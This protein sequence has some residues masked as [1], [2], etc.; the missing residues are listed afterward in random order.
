MRGFTSPRGRPRPARRNTGGPPHA[1]TAPRRSAGF[2]AS[3]TPELLR[4]LYVEITTAC[5]LNCGMC[6]RHVGHIAD[7]SMSRATWRRLLRQ[8]RRIPS[9]ATVQFGGF[10]EPTIHPAFFDFLR[11]V[12]EAGLRAELVTNGTTLDRSFTGRLVEA[13]L[14]QLV[15]S[16]DGADGTAEEVLHPWQEGAVPRNLQQLRHAKLRR[17]AADPEVAIEF[18][19]TRANIARLP[20]VKRLSQQLGFSRILVTNLIPYRQDLEEQVL[21]RHWATAKRDAASSPVDPL[22][23]LPRLDAGSEAGEAVERLQRSGTRL[24][25][26]GNDFSIG[27][28]H[29]RFVLEGCM[30]VGPD[31]SV[32]PCLPLLHTHRYYFQQEARQVRAYRLGNVQQQTL[33]ELWEEAEYRAFRQRVANQA[34][35]PCIDCGGCELRLAN[36][37]DCYGNGFPCCGACLWA[38]GVVQ[39]P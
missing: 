28:M 10:G 37:A 19:A 14:D 17:G 34:F 27:G 21:Y 18:V 5:N 31:G 30:A 32:S 11:D 23:N 9:L 25:V 36:E 4:K 33:G 39:C 16:F 7:A 1:D 24:Q 22:V 38:A 3:A 12:K 2:G 13:Q 8:A 35:A 29:C 6:V 26:L 20:Q 15:V